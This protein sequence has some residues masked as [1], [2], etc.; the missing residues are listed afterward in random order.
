MQQHFINN[1]WIA[2]ASG[3]AID[4]IDKAVAVKKTLKH[5]MASLCSRRLPSSTT[6]SP[7]A[8]SFHRFQF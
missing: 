7:P 5:C 8:L 3:E 6:A 1:R 2:G 4:V